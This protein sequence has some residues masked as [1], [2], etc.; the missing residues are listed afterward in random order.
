M[1]FDPL[2]EQNTLGAAEVNDDPIENMRA[3]VTQC[4]RL[5]ATIMDDRATEALLKMASDI[6]ADII[7][8]EAERDG[9]RFRS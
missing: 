6:E 2:A 8:L 7:R 1:R 9:D 4:R 3:R 5:A